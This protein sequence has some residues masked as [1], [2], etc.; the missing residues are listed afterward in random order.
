[1]ILETTYKSKNNK[2]LIDDL[3]GSSFSLMDILKLR[4]IGS[5][6]MVID[7][8]SP[9]L[10]GY[11]NT[12]TDVNYG[13]IELRPNGVLIAINKGLKNFIWVIP[14]YQFNFYKTNGVSIHAQGRFVHFKNNRTLK[15]NKA[16]FDKMIK[17][18]VEYDQRYPHID[19]IDLY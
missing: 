4:G 19:T 2:E 5:K 14:Y 11:L 13:N 1:M 8:V 12:V 18:K 10:Q 6:R 15:E 16:F 7:E 9:N 17:F 3:I